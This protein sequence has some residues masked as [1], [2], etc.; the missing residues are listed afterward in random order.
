MYI[1]LVRNF[2][3]LTLQVDNFLDSLINFDKNHIHEN[4]IR[5]VQTYLRSPEFKPEVVEAKSQ[6]AAGLCSWVI[7]VLKYYEVTIVLSVLHPI[8]CALLN[9]II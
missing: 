6:A 7:N 3:Y 4:S 5:A 8:L 2:T 9:M 1:I